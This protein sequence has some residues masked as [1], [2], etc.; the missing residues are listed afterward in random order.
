LR[1]MSQ[2]GRTLMVKVRLL[3]NGE[4]IR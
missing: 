3:Q 1:G 4:G 2:P